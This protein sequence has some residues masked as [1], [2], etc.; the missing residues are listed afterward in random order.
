MKHLTTLKAFSVALLVVLVFSLIIVSAKAVTSRLQVEWEQFLPG[1]SGK[2]II[3]TSDGGYLVLGKNATIYKENNYTTAKFVDYVPI[4]EKIDPEGNLLWSKTYEVQGVS[5]ELYGLIQTSDGGY[6]LAGGVVASYDKNGYA[7]GQFC[8]LKLD[9]EGNVLWNRTYP[10]PEPLGH[11]AFTSLL[12]TSN[13]NYVLVGTY[14]YAG[15]Y[16]Y[17]KGAPQLFFA[18]VDSL[19]NMMINKTVGYGGGIAVVPTDDEGYT[20]AASYPMSG[21]GSHFQLVKVDPEGNRQ[22][23][24]EY[25]KEGGVSSSIYCGTTAVDGGYLLGG[26]YGYGYRLLAKIDSEGEML[27]NQTYDIGAIYS[28]TK[29]DDGGYA[30]CGF[31]KSGWIAKTDSLGNI[32]AELSTGLG[33]PYSILQSNDGGY[34]CVGTWNESN[35][36]STNQKLWIAKIGLTEIPDFPVVPV[37]TSVAVALAVVAGL[38]FYFRKLRH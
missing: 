4:V 34:A 3:Q 30:L 22:W 2:R 18:K 7:I 19:G 37:A 14:N 33:V 6:A 5:P 12:Q 24:Q 27:W 17:G 23:V 16:T 13:G 38:L 20:I 9:S 21:G 29:T 15:A 28:I 10:D 26:N 11:A 36:A 31:S 32:K 1:I 8:L 35:V 25:M